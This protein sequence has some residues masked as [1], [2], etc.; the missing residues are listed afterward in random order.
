MPNFCIQAFQRQVRT[1]SS[2]A[3]EAAVCCEA[4]EVALDG[5]GVADLES[6]LLLLEAE[7]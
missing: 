5:A 1:G 4:F 2:E 6:A 3:D 7:A